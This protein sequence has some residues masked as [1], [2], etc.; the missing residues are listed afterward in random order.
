[1]TLE[2]STHIGPYEVEEQIGSGST[3]LVFR[4]R[5][6]ETDEPMAVKVL[7]LV[8]PEI[9]RRMEKEGRVQAQLHHPNIVRVLEILDVDGRLGLVL[10]YVDG[11]S[12]DRWLQTKPVP[13]IA[14]RQLVAT[15]IVE[16]VAY[17]HARGLVHR[18]LKPTNVLLEW[19][20]QGLTPRIT[21]FGL[22][23]VLGEAP[24][25]MDTRTG[26][27]LGTPRYM[28]PEQIH[29]AK[30]V[31]ARADVFSLGCVLYEIY[32]GR[33][34]FPQKDMLSV[35]NA[36]CDGVL[37]DPAEVADD[38]PPHVA[39]AIR[40]ALSVNPDDRPAD[41]SALLQILAPGSKAFAFQNTVPPQRSPAARM[42]PT[43]PLPEWVVGVS[44]LGLGM[45]VGTTM[46][47]AA[48]VAALFFWWIT[49]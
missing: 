20:D 37:D 27:T 23:K 25:P 5:H 43:Q 41:A 17:A 18:D 36:V 26:H 9:H 42:P 35:F 47:L 22:A 7:T 32:C 24:Q 8:H 45:L 4:V 16:G 48:V 33:Q 30:H 21:D 44:L 31:D 19:T 14:S 13:D 38:V 3:A 15:Q 12:L 40:A 1:M 49:G 39:A 6:P 10:E 46:G 28:S 11:P 34:A 29:S 2:E